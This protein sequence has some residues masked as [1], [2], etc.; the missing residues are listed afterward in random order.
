MNCF[1]P[2]DHPTSP[3]YERGDIR[4][5]KIIGRL[6]DTLD[7]FVQTR[8]IKHLR[9]P[10]IVANLM[11]VNVSQSSHRIRQGEYH[12]LQFVLP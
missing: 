1:Y 4:V 8:I 3:L 9:Y 12:V 2:Y 10:F 6:Q 7:A 11:F 5:K